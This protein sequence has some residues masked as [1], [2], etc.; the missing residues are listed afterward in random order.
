MQETAW[1]RKASEHGTDETDNLQIWKNGSSVKFNTH[2]KTLSL[3][4]N[5]RI[6]VVLCEITATSLQKCGEVK[7]KEKERLILFTYRSNYESPG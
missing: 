5:K 3:T 2:F 4:S 1:Y 6:S 7:E